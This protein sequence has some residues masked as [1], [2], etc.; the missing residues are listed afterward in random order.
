MNKISV[1]VIIPT[2]NR[3]KLLPRAI[4]SVLIQTTPAD[5][6]IVI[7]DGSTDETATIVQ[8]EFTRIKYIHQDNQGI[9]A[10]RNSG[11]NH[12]QGEW[13]AFLDSDD[14]WLPA[15]LE[16]QKSALLNNP[17]Y[18]I[19]HTDE[20]W[21]RN[22]RRVNPHKK[23]QKY[24]GEIYKFCLP[25]CVI[26]PSSVLI[27]KQVFTKLGNFDTT[28]PACED[29]DMW[30]RICAY[31]PVL[32]IDEPLMI[33]YGGHTDQLS[34][35]YWG[36]DRFRIQALEKMLSDSRLS[37]DNRLLTLEMIVQKI[38]IFLVGAHK[39]NRPEVIQTYSNMLELYSKQL[40]E[41]KVN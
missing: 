6:I 37:P 25:L 28:L 19:C 23:H 38:E 9:S 29:Y 35:K 15:K 24:G 8:S 31:N 4:Q 5:E 7:D 18:R 27:H 26:S 16:K 32:Y 41:S 10:A 14:E 34:K 3:A 21:I 36:M 1:S 22:G 39:R 20:I 30:L 11:I 13:I 17:E 40:E 2:F 33:K 12:A